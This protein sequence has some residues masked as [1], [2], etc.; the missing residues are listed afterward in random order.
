MRASARTLD[1]RATATAGS[2]AG[3]APVARLP[4]SAPS[5]PAA[6]GWTWRRTPSKL[7]LPIVL[8]AG[9]AAVCCGLI[10]TAA[11]VQ[12]LAA[13][14]TSS[15]VVVVMLHPPAAAYLLVTLTP[16]TVGINRGA[17]LPLLRPN[18]A[19]AV[20]LA[21]ALGARALLRMR[22][23]ARHRL[24]LNRID[25][26]LLAFTVSASLLPLLIMSLRHRAITSD[27]I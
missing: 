16:L 2:I 13:T 21:L 19:L 23:A 27:D 5:V 10:A 17:A 12:V 1:K 22:T 24:R 18:E 7:S 11:P 26:A 6:L 3:H 25:T 14:A 20:I 15:V 9:F 4:R 8:C